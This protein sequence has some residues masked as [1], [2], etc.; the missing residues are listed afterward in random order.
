M[1]VQFGKIYRMGLTQELA[2]L[3]TVSRGITKGTLEGTIRH[4]VELSFEALEERGSYIIRVPF[5]ERLEPDD[6]RVGEVLK[7]IVE[8][9]QVPQSS[10]RSPT[11]SLEPS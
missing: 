11:P 8:G 9:L 4:F 5:D 1:K 6:P 2:R 3:Q 10:P 7:A